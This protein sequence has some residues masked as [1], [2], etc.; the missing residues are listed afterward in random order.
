[1]WPQ[2]TL[3]FQ[4]DLVSLVRDTRLS[5]FLCWKHLGADDAS[6]TRGRKP[7]SDSRVKVGILHVTQNVLTVTLKGRKLLSCIALDYPRQTARCLLANHTLSS[8]N[9]EIH[10][11]SIL[12]LNLSTDTISTTFSGNFFQSFTTR[13]ANELLF[14]LVFTCSQNRSPDDSQCLIHP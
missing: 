6:T 12:P 13:K 2:A 3:Q 4:L 8:P 1:M 5:S 10:V 14:N 9:T 11:L 7:S